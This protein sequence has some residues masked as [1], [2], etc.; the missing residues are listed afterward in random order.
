VARRRRLGIRPARFLHLRAGSAPSGGWYVG[1]EEVDDSYKV[2]QVDP[3][4]EQEIIEAAF[5]RLARKYHPDLNPAPDAAARMRDLNA[6]YDTLKDPSRRAE[7]DRLR[8]VRRWPWRRRRPPD[9]P[10]DIGGWADA[11]GNGAGGPWT[12]RP[13]CW[14]HAPLPAVTACQAC[15]VTLCRYC[16]SPFQPAGCA[17]CVLRRAHRMLCRAAAG[18]TIFGVVFLAV[19]YVAIVAARTRLTGALLIAYLVAATAFGVAVIAGRMWRS[20]WLDEP[21]D[22][23]L[24]VTFLVWAG[25]VVGWAGAPVLLLKMAWDFRR[26]WQLAETARGLTS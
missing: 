10:P 17:P 3:R 24:G 2:L 14:R 23:D 11:A 21:R 26:A 6:A 16:A 4:A 18:A 13:S 22:R 8:S 1:E 5:R 25:I 12:D 9:A 19:L 15:G 7:Y 20:G